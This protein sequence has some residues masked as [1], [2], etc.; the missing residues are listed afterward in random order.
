MGCCGILFLAVKA[1][2]LASSSNILV[3]QRKKLRWF[4]K[5]LLREQAIQNR[6]PNWGIKKENLSFKNTTLNTTDIWFTKYFPEILFIG[7][8]YLVHSLILNQDS[9]EGMLMY[10]KHHQHHRRKDHLCL[11]IW[12]PVLILSLSFPSS[13]TSWLVRVHSAN[14]ICWWA[15]QTWRS[16]RHWALQVELTYLQE[17]SHTLV[18][19]LFITKNFLLVL[20]SSLC[21]H[22]AWS[23]HSIYSST[24]FAIEHTD[25]RRKATTRLCKKARGESILQ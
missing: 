8:A 20:I 3:T 16:P 1:E 12:A 11:R 18:C 5:G 4:T 2:G 19:Y 17:A 6:T 22:S 7:S 23:K 15:P 14:I 21:K 25:S 9:G 10:Y 24:W 13:R